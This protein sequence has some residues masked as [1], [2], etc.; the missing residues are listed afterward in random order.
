MAVIRIGAPSVESAAG[1]LSAI[2]NYDDQARTVSIICTGTGHAKL[3][4]FD[5]T[6]TPAVR[7][8]VVWLDQFGSTAGPL[9][10]GH[11]ASPVTHDGVAPHVVAGP[12]AA[13][14]QDDGSA[15]P[16]QRVQGAIVGALNPPKGQAASLALGFDWTAN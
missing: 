12:G 13:G 2:I 16:T 3:S 5:N 11:S 7:L 15:L 1:S 9:T 10:K 4:L 14:V 6:V 8:G